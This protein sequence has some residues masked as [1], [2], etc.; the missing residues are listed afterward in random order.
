MSEERGKEIW[1]CTLREYEEFLEPVIA[2]QNG[3]GIYEKIPNNQWGYV[4]NI[5]KEQ[6]LKITSEGLKRKIKIIQIK[7]QK[8]QKVRLLF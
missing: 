2:K 5:S 4:R 6:F 8:Y 7:I 3:E 1:D